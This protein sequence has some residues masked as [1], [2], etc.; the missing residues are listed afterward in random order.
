MQLTT[1]NSNTPE[2]TSSFIEE[3]IG[4]ANLRIEKDFG[5]GFVRLKTSEAEK[6]QA[7]QDIRSSEDIVIE[8]LRN[9]RD[10]NAK[11]IFLATQREADK[12]SIV[13]ID[14]GCGLPENMRSLVFE[15]RVTSK[16]DTASLDRWGFHGRGMALYSIRVNSSIARIVDSKPGLGTS[17]Q[18]VVDTKN[19]S[20]KTD[21]STFPRF[22]MQNGKMC[23][24]GPKNILRTAAE[25]ALEHKDSVNVYCGSFTEIATAINEYGMATCS[26]AMRA[27][28]SNIDECKLIQRLAF[29]VD[30]VEF[31]EIASSLGLDMSP[32]S[33]RRIM[34]GEI[35]A[36]VVMLERI[37]HESLSACKPQKFDTPKKMPKKSAVKF[38]QNDIDSF[39][40]TVTD[41]FRELASGYFLDDSVNPNV[42]VINGSLKVEIPLINAD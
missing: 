5:Q 41:A 29:A 2:I 27:F 11:N 15:P 34:D 24:R 9:S 35:K 36:A 39:T 13:V 1:Q 40:N 14:D 22:E 17:I 38:T 16:L 4:D 6:R 28:S 23:M 37:K 20:E 10:A 33:S 21:Q 12:R 31:S 30:P 7:A 32:R 19:I 25:F 18:V 42:H 8:L 26:P 3:V